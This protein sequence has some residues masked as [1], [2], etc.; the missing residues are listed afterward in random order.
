[1]VKRSI[2]QN[3]R[4]ENFG[5]RIG[6]FEKN[7]VVKYQRRKQRE[8]RIL[9]DCW[10]W[11]ANGQCSKGDNCSFRHDTN[12]RANQTRTLLQNLLRS[13][14]RQ[15][16]REPKVPEAEAQVGERLHRRRAM[17]TSKGLAQLHSVKNGIL[18][19]ACSTS[20]RMD[21]DLWTSALT[22]T[23]RLTNSLARSLKIMVTKVQWL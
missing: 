11:K 23:A 15:M 9:G 17:I 19:S 10:Q 3:L 8:Q 12:K 6:N 14:V 1:M 20:Q 2:E 4:I 18:W 7:A 13:R 16:H 21:A 22:H 5:N